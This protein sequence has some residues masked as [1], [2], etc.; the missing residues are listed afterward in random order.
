MMS[1]IN[2]KSII[3]IIIKNTHNLY[4]LEVITQTIISNVIFCFYSV[5]SNGNLFQNI[6]SQLFSKIPKNKTFFSEIYWQK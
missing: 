6:F 4:F 3:K 1:L 5:P 2:E